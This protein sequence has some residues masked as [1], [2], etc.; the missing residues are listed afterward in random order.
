MRCHHCDRMIIH[1]CWVIVLLGNKRVKTF[2]IDGD[3]FRI[4]MTIVVQRFLWGYTSLWWHT[5]GGHTQIALFLLTTC[6]VGWR[7]NNTHTRTLLYL[8]I[9]Q[10]NFGLCGIVGSGS[11]GLHNHTRTTDI[12]NSNVNFNNSRNRQ[13]LAQGRWSRIHQRMSLGFCL[14]LQTKLRILI[15]QYFIDIS[16]DLRLILILLPCCIPCCH[17]LTQPFF[18][19]RRYRMTTITK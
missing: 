1:H 3:Y 12:V 13:I 19:Q 4:I 15:T 6:I 8:R 17:A 11:S 18:C 7:T 16:R 14:C 10:K 5:R 9:H 2:L